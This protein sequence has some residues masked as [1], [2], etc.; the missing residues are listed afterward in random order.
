[1]LK[2][3]IERDSDGYEFLDTSMIDEADFDQAQAHAR[4]LY[5]QAMSNGDFERELFTYP[6]FAR[7]IDIV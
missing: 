2:C 4:S 5:V 6:G 3:K 1:V 7:L